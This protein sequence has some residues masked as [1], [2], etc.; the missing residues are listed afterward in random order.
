MALNA[1]AVELNG[2]SLRTIRSAPMVTRAAPQ[3]TYL[4]AAHEDPDLSLVHA[5]E[6]WAAVGGAANAGA[7]V[8]VA[9]IDSGIDITHPC[10][11]DTGYAAQNQLGDPDLTNNKVIVAKV[12]DN[13]IKKDD[14]D[15]ERRRLA[16]ARTSPAPSPVTRTRRRSSTASTS[17]TTRPG[18]R[19]APSSAT[20]T[21]SPAT[22]A[23]PAPRTSSTRSR[24]PTRTASTSPT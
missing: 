21:S 10:F 23:R 22:P 14:F 9:V 1:V 2:T 8:K 11:D 5:N 3:V 24:T 18:S 16:T 17:R 19:R 12:Y 4:R 20:T 7:G 6:A 13:K 15:A